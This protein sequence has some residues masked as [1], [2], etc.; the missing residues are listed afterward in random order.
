GVVQSINTD[1]SALA[2]VNN[3]E[4]AFQEKNQLTV[5][6]YHYFEPNLSNKESVLLLRLKM[7]KGKLFFLSLIGVGLAMKVK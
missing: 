5:G 4:F 6:F 2:S 7:R 1:A 3:A